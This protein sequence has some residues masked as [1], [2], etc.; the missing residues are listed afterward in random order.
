MKKW[1]MIGRGF[2]RRLRENDTSSYASSIAFFLFLSFIP[3]LMLVC[4]VLPYTP[5]TEAGLMRIIQEIVPGSVEPMM[6]SLV[7]QVYDKSAGILSLA[8]FIT[9]WSAG[10]GMLALMRA[11]NAANEVAEER[12]YFRLRIL[13]SFYTVITLAAVLITLCLGVFGKQIFLFLQKKAPILTEGVSLLDRFRFIFVLLILIFVFGLIYT[14]IPNRKTRL[15]Y[16]LPGAGFAGL[17]CNICSFAF[18]LY[19]EYFN[20]FSA[21]GS[22]GTIIIFLLWLYFYCYILL[23]G[24]HLNIYFQPI[25]MFIV[26]KFGKK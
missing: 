22:L 20:A 8:V 25:N 12:G 18:S 2:T 23:I 9:I 14:Y 13:A 19:V 1:Y 7:A 10:K 21:Y 4:A 26:D 11:L 3:V 17:A 15:L 6:V 5:L 16:Q 24:A